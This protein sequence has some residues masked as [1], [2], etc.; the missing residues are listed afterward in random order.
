MQFIQ[1]YWCAGPGDVEVAMASIKELIARE[2]EDEKVVYGPIRWDYMLPEQEGCPSV[3]KWMPEGADPRLLVGRTE[4]VGKLAQKSDPGASFLAGLSESE[5][6]HLRKITRQAAKKH[7]HTLTNSECDE[8]IMRLGP[9][10]AEA[11]LRE[12]VG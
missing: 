3:P 11:A 12:K 10:A 9:K 1:S 2:A 4:P 8:T 7:G 5:L 6:W